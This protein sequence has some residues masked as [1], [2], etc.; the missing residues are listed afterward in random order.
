M[1]KNTIK[2]GETRLVEFKVHNTRT[3]KVSC[4]VLDTRLAYGRIEYKVAPVE[5]EGAIWITEAT[6]L[7]VK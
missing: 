1:S 2:V 5:G 4:V 6:V 3:V 7:G